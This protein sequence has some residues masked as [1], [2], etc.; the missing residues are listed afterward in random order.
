MEFLKSSLGLEITH[1]PFKG[2]GQ[3]VPALVG[4]QVPMVFSAYPSLAAYAKDGR[5][6]LLAANSL[7]RAAFAQN[8][9]TISETVPGFDFAPTVGIFAPRGTPRELVNRISADALEVVK[10]ADTVTRML[11]RR[12]RTRKR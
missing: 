1:V 8:I 7:K 3:S 12:H 11:N 2:T 4:G 5:V 9:P 6:K 10:L